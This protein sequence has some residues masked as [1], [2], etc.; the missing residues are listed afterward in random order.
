MRDLERGRDQTWRSEER[1]T[2]TRAE[3][4]RR[5]ITKNPPAVSTNVPAPV[6]PT[7]LNAGENLGM[8]EIQSYKASGKSEIAARASARSHQR[9]T[10]FICTRSA[11][12]GNKSRP[13]ALLRGQRKSCVQRRESQGS[14]PGPGSFIRNAA[15]G[16]FE[17]SE[18]RAGIKTLSQKDLE[19]LPVKEGGGGSPCE[20]KPLIDANVSGVSQVLANS[21]E[22][23]LKF[24]WEMLCWGAAA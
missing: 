14:S 3:G 5:Q 24:D 18:S 17:P 9:A 22:A 6:K 7:S 20:S 15:S 1:S 16:M 10:K 19:S 2:S 21:A 4:P 13:L 12:V 8:R 23:R 11:G